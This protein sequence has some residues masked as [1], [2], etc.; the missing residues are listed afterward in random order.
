VK[1]AVFHNQPSGGARRALHGFCQAL[2]ERGHRIDFFTLTT[3]DTEMLRDEVV[4]SSVT[5]LPFAFRPSVR[6]GLYLNDIRRRQSFADLERVNA[7]AAKLIDAGQYDVALV[8]A[9]RFTFAPRVLRHLH[10][11]S[12]YFC[13]HRPARLF[14]H[15]FSPPVS[16]YERARQLLHWPLER[17]LERRLWEDDRKL[18]RLADRV[19]T[20]SS[21]T[22]D[23]IREVYGIEATVCPYGVELP[24]Y[25]PARRKDYVLSVGELEVR[26]GFDFV[27]DSLAKLPDRPPLHI[28]ANGGNPRVREALEAQ[29]RRLG[30]G[31]T[32]RILPPQSELA[33]EY[34]EAA[35]FVYGAREEALGLAPLEAMA[36][37]TP[38]VAVAEG[39]V[40]ETVRDGVSGFLVERQAERFG[41]RLAQLL[42]SPELRDRMGAA[43]R[44]AIE[45][46]WTWPLRALA[47]ERELLAL[48]RTA[49]VDLP[50]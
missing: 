22:K 27:L 45:E 3:A 48:A 5:V 25:V 41:A 39:G 7:H 21:F 38:V 50:A 28:V 2:A 17:D 31:L 20:N 29:A 44:A 47:L 46:H 30:V 16:V 4:A 8:D 12:A 18:V 40:R 36:S 10:T 14:E 49:P 35:V 34:R 24:P 1:I 26:K 23:L 9:C 43:G 33:R 13:H 15:A 42:H 37:G 11:P 19:I 32:I 6:R